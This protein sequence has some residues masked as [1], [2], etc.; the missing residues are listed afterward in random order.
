M[1]V[2]RK[3]GHLQ[4]QH[5]GLKVRKLI[6]ALRSLSSSHGEGNCI[7]FLG[8]TPLSNQVYKYMEVPANIMLG[9]TLQWTNILSRG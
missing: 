2:G 5:S 7:V 6:S 3:L 8:K 9:V 4:Y 1:R